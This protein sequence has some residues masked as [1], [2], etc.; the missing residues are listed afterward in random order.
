MAQ[1]PQIDRQQ[2]LEKDQRPSA[3]AHRMEDLQRDARFIVVKPHQPAVVLLEAHRLAGIGDIRLHEGTGGMVGLEIMPERPP[4][5][6]HGKAGKA[7]HGPLHRP[8]EGV[9]VHRS[10]HD[11]GKA[12]DGGIVLLLNGGVQYA[13]VVQR[14]PLRLAAP[15]VLRHVPA[16]SSNSVF[17]SIPRYGTRHKGK[18]AVSSPSF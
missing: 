14:I 17:F 7:G 10:G 4:F 5:D 18:P 9:G 16:P 3:V 13:R 1:F 8:L 6:P 15:P 12:V 11:G 2:G